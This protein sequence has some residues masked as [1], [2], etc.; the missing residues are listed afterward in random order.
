MTTD[1]ELSVAA[2]EAGKRLDI[3][4]TQRLGIFSRARI[5]SLIKAGQ[6]TIKGQPLKEHRKTR[7]GETVQVVIPAPV[8]TA[9]RPEPIALDILYQDAD[10]IVVNKPAGLVVHPAAGHSSGTLVNALLYHCPDLTGIGHELRPG[11]IHRLDKDTSGVLVVAKNERAL[12]GLAAQ[13]K[14]QLVEKYYLALVWGRPQ[15]PQGSIATLIG[16]HAR[17]RKRMTARPRRGRAALT[18]YTSL[19]TLGPASLLRINIITGRTHQIRVHMA[20][21]GW[22]IVGDKQ[23]GLRVRQQLP[24]P[25]TRQMLHAERLVLNQP[26][27]GKRLSFQAPLAA[28]MELLL[29]ALRR[30]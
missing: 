18:H 4:L 10:I 30:Q 29:Q 16:R 26:L 6:V 20:H 15:P 19:E 12:T 7:A 25:A 28:D 1:Y 11:I 22:P 21:R 17:D 5:Q 8:S 27:S 14:A 13:F 2:E 23:Y 3:W 9:L 24:R